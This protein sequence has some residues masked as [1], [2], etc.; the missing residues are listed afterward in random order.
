MYSM[1]ISVVV[2]VFNEEGNLR[3]VYLEIKQVL[4]QH[5]PNYEI[6]FVD[7]GSTDGS[8]GILRDIHDK[9]ARVKIIQFRKNFGQTSAFSAGIDYASGELIVT[10][11]A[12]GQ[13][14]PEDIPRLLAEIIDG[15]YDF[16]TGWRT[17]RKESF[18]RRLFSKTAN[19]II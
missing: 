14:N 8:L 18:V 12:D 16:V 9:D 13:N 11:D 17:N 7:D 5:A 3:P 2:P 1:M 19:L 4:D 15:D 10:I 6:I